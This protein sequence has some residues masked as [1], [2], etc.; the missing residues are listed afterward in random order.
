MEGGENLNLFWWWMNKV[1]SLLQ[2]FPLF[3]PSSFF[4]LG[5]FLP[6]CKNTKN[7]CLWEHNFVLFMD[8]TQKYDNILDFIC[9]SRSEIIP[10]YCVSDHLDQICTIWSRI[11]MDLQAWPHLMD[12]HGFA[13]LIMLSRVS[14][15]NKF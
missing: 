6:V 7:D 10:N 4:G 3:L 13:H 5:D 11:G 2:S 14:F 8:F 15:Y 1:N 12:E 9:V